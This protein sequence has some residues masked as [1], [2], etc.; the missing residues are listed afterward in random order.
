[1]IIDLFIIYN[2]GFEFCSAQIS[3]VSSN[4]G[5]EHFEE[6]VHLS[7]YIRY[8]KTLGLKYYAGMNDAPVYELLR[9]SIINTENQLMD[10]SDYNWQACTDTVRST[11]AHII[12]Y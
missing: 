12:F 9:Q 5:K 3:K 2:S 8:N 7:R 6:L 1:M 4:P 10:F 11:G